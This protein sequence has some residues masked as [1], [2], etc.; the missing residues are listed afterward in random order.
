MNIKNKIAAASASA[1]I[2][3]GVL[4]NAAFASTNITISGNLKKSENKVI[5]KQANVTA[6]LQGNAQT[7][8]TVVN[9]S[10]STGG[11]K[12][13]DNMGDVSIKTGNATSKVT[14]L[15]GG[16]SNT[17]TLSCG[18]AEG[19]TDVKIKDNGK[20]SKNTVVQK[21]LDLTLVGQGNIAA[22][23][24]GVGSGAETGDNKA[25]GTGNKGTVEV[26]TKDAKSTVDVVVEGG[27]NVLE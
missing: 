20:K 3:S 24:T 25:N 4:S 23:K 22:V 14:V 5:V 10:A 19:A 17:A 15:V 16:G 12:A 8:N 27:T 18:C 1:V 6:V 13:N 7:V 21:S 11:N 2:L 9:S 26:E